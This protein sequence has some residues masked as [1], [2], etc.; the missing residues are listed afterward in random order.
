MTPSEAARLLGV[1]ADSVRVLSDNGKLPT[2]RTVSGRRLFWR[3]DVEKLAAERSDG[4][5]QGSQ[6]KR[7]VDGAKRADGQSRRSAAEASDGTKPRRTRA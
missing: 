5:A 6:D 3:G 4:R 1:S 7:R 2:L